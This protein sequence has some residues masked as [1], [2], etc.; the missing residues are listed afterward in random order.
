MYSK[1]ALTW[2]GAPSSTRQLGHL[3]LADGLNAQLGDRLVEALGQQA[4]DH[5]LADLRGEA[6]PDHR[7]RHLAG[8]EAG[9]L[10][11]F[12]VIAGDAAPSFGDFVGGNVDHN[13]T[14]AFGIQNRAVLV[15]VCFFGVIVICWVSRFRFVFEGAAGAQ[16]FTFRLPA[17]T[18]VSMRPRSA[19]QG[20]SAPSGR[21]N[22]SSYGTGV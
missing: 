15:I 4:V 19:I 22:P 10:G 21:G 3:R 18:P 14:G 13:L 5:F 9:N 12:A 6:A 7:L 1:T 16:R 2:S 11:V 8:A 17:R 20:D